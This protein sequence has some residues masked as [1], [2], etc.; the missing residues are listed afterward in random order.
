[1]EIGT[2]VVDDLADMRLLI[3][4]IIDAANDGLFV[5]QT[6][7]SGREALD[8]VDEV[9]PVIV[10]LDEMMPGMNGIETAQLL[11]KRR[12]GQLMIMCSAYLDEEL[13]ARAEEA[14]ILLCVPKERVYEIPKALRKIAEEAR[15]A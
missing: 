5:K 15:I 7:A 6:A 9:D 8:M 14:G 2:L 11:R 3:R 4:M 13:K 1:V 10:V 12:P